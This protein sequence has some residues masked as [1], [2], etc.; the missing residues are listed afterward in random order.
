MQA[1]GYSAAAIKALVGRSSSR[2]R[3][4]PSTSPHRGIRVGLLLD[5]LPQGQLPRGV[6]G[7]P[8]HQRPRRQGQVGPLSQRVPAHGHQGAAARRQL[9]DRQLR[10]GRFR[11]PLRARSDPQRRAQ[12]RR[13][14]RRRADAEKGDFISFEDFLRKCPATVLNKRTIESLVKAG[15]FDSLGHP[16]A[17]LMRIHE[18]Y[19]DAL[20]D[21]KR[22]E[23]IGQ[24]SLFGDFGFGDGDG[25]GAMARRGAAAH[26]RGRVGQAD[27]A[28]LRARDAR[29]LR[30]RSPALRHRARPRGARRHLDRRRSWARSGAATATPSPSPAWSP[31]L[32]LKRNKKGDLWAIAT[33]EDLDGAIEC[34]VLPAAYNQ[35]AT[36]W[37][38]TSS[39]PSA[40][41]STCA[42][43]PSRSTPRS[44]PSPTSPK[45]HAGRSSCR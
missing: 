3:T 11:H 4:T 33:V 13:V 34:S 10:C 43:T 16:R 7:R 42:T 20:A 5:R 38:P 9:L 29:A 40:A 22:Q 41:G 36:R 15:A 39:C 27:P 35:V 8:A 6:H 25:G 12:R 19:V 21:E 32:Q 18:A 24:D 26:P 31:T 2:S 1:N 37:C 14:D 23:A 45:A 44:S 28:H 17:G 30:L